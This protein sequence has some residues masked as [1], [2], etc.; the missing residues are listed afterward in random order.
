[1][2][3]T[4]I[5]LYPSNWLYNAGVVGL[6]KVLEFKKKSFEISDCVQ[7]ERHIIKESYNGIF[8]YHKEVLK[9][10]SFSIVGKNK[11]YPNYIQPSRKD[12]S[13]KEFFEN[14]YIQKLQNAEKD[15]DKS[16]SWC[17]GYFIPQNLIKNMASKFKGD[18][19]AFMEQR[20]K[21]QGI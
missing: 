12:F 4:K 8:E 10:E 9:E 16:C 14:Y 7:L 17:E 20:E 18:F 1:M 19:S 11:R 2:A 13:P 3:E 5:T 15:K 21:F 6:L